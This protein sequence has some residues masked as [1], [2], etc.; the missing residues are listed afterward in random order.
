MSVKLIQ[1][2]KEI[3]QNSDPLASVSVADNVTIGLVYSTDGATPTPNKDTK[4]SITREAAQLFLSEPENGFN[5][6]SATNLLRGSVPV[7]SSLG[8]AESRKIALKV[9]EDNTSVVV[10]TL[11]ELRSLFNS[12]FWKPYL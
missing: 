10:P 7:V 12:T 4:R 2:M 8:D 9:D 11:V 1:H 5:Y 3:I 6:S